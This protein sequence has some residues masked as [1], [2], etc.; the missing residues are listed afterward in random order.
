MNTFVAYLVY[1]F[2]SIFPTIFLFSFTF[3]SISF[4]L[5]FVSYFLPLFML[6]C[7]NTRTHKHRKKNNQKSFLSQTPGKWWQKKREW[8]K[9]NAKTPKKNKKNNFKNNFH[10]LNSWNGNQVR[11]FFFALLEIFILCFERDRNACPK[12]IPSIT[13]IDEI[14]YAKTSDVF[15]AVSNALRTRSFHFCTLRL[16]TWQRVW[17]VKIKRKYQSFLQVKIALTL[18]CFEAYLNLGSV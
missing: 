5:L 13:N 16:F 11:Y 8:P 2:F 17:D 12:F 7:I 6:F 3:L 9:R 10:I 4:G 1:I 15:D 14:S 18:R